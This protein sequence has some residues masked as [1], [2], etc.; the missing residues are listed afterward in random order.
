MMQFQNNEPKVVLVAEDDQTLAH[1]IRRHLEQEGFHPIVV[2][3]GQE[4]LRLSATAQPSVIVL[5]VGLPDMNGLDLCRQ[6]KADWRTANVPVLFLTGLNEIGDKLAGFEA[7]AQDYLVKPFEMTEFKARIRAILNKEDEVN[8]ARADLEQRQHDFMDMINDELRAPLTVIGIATHLLAE[9]HQLSEERREQLL[10]SIHTS[11]GTLTQI[12]DDLLYL[13]KPVRHLRTCNIRATLQTVADEQRRRMQELDLHLIA[14]L[15]AT[16]PVIAV[17]ETMLRR[18][19]G[20]LI[21]NAIKFTQRGGVITI[22]ADVVQHGKVGNG[23]SDRVASL[24]LPPG[25]LPSDEGTWLVVAVRDTGI[26][27]APEHHRR[28]FEPFYQVN[29]SL[30]RPAPGMGLGLAVVASF[31]RTHHGHLAVRSGMNQGT[32]I[33][34]ALPLRQDDAGMPSPPERDGPESA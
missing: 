3:S 19:M 12:I 34:L 22:T 29:S 28:V 23:E 20:H 14:R 15:P 11:A 4:T 30:A 5:D 8:N 13:V 2:E 6:I 16:L 33:H 10:Q 24:D 1:F 21:D 7:G 18:S 31:V 17:D 25:L 27:I 26:G 9:N 32:A